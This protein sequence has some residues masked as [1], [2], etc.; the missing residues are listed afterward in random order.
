MDLADVRR[1]GLALI[2]E[3]GLDGWRLQFDQA[4]RR[5]GICRYERSI[6]GLSGPL[7]RL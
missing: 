6:I 3:H 4:R 2:A 5:A 1:L 7:M